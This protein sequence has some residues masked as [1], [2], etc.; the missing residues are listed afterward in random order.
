VL[1]CFSR[2]IV[3]W[4]MDTT[5]TAG[6][7]MDALGMA[8]ARRR[9]GPG[10]LHHSDRGSQYASEAYQGLLR[11]HGIDL[12]MSRVGDCYDNAMKESFWSTLKRETLTM[13]PPGGLVFETITQARMAMFEYIEVFYNRK[14]RHSSLGYISPEAFE[15]ALN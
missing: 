1:D 10:L 7:V 14:R 9:P 8:L 3:G 4:S 12:S 5:M 15:A 11:E 6:L 13:K 2:R